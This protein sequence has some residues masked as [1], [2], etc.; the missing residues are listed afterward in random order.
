MHQEIANQSFQKKKGN[1]TVLLFS[2]S[3]VSISMMEDACQWTQIIQ[4]LSP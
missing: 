2:T 3:D 1:L 4:V